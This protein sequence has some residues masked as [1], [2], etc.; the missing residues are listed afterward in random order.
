MCYKIKNCT[1]WDSF[2]VVENMELI[3]NG[4]IKNL[5]DLLGSRDNEEINSDNNCSFCECFF[6][7]QF[8]HG[9]AVF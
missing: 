5:M 4:N 1:L 8:F 9:T 3:Y 6:Y 7:K 2:W